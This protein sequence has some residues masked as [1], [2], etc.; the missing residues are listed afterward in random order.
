MN[1]Y[2]KQHIS[3]NDIIKRKKINEI[4]VL[5]V[6]DEETDAMQED[7]QNY[8]IPSVNNGVSTEQPPTSI[9]T[10]NTLTSTTVKLKKNN[11]HI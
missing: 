10:Q 4:F 9:D 11:I 2:E 5:K 1:V 3:L 7:T 8:S 6:N